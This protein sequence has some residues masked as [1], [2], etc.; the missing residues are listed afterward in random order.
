MK[1]SSSSEDDPPP[2]RYPL[3]KSPF[4]LPTE[5]TLVMSSP[6]LSIVETHIPHLL[7]SVDPSTVL[8]IDVPSNL[9]EIYSRWPSKTSRILVCELLQ[10]QV[11]LPKF[12]ILPS[13]KRFWGG[14]PVHS[15]LGFCLTLLRTLWSRASISGVIIAHLDQIKYASHNLKNLAKSVGLSKMSQILLLPRYHVCFENLTKTQPYNT[16]YNVSKVQKE[17]ESK[18]LNLLILAETIIQE[19]KSKAVGTGLFDPLSNMIEL[20]ENGKNEEQFSGFKYPGILSPTFS[21]RWVNLINRTEESIPPALKEC[22]YWLTDVSKLIAQSYSR[23]VLYGLFMID[24]VNMKSQPWVLTKAGEQVLRDAKC[25]EIKGSKVEWKT[26]K[27][28]LEQIMMEINESRERRREKR[29]RALRKGKPIK[30]LVRGTVDTLIIT[31]KYLKY[32]ALVANGQSERAEYEARKRFLNKKCEPLKNRKLSDLPVEGQAL[33]SEEIRVKNW[34]SDKQ[35]NP[36][37]G[38][39]SNPILCTLYDELPKDLLSYFKRLK[40]ANV[41]LLGDWLEVVRTLEIYSNWVGSEGSKY[42]RVR[43]WSVGGS[44][45]QLAEEESAFERIIEDKKS[46]T[47][48]SSTHQS[49]EMELALHNG[50]VAG[51]YRD[52][53]GNEMPLSMDTRVGR[54]VNSELGRTIIVD[55]RELRNTT[56]SRLHQHGFRLAP[57]QL[58]VGDF[59]LTKNIVV[60]KKTLQDLRNS[61]DNGRLFEQ[62]E[63]MEKHYSQSILLLEFKGDREADPVTICRGFNDIEESSAKSIITKFVLLLGRF[64]K[65]RILWSKSPQHTAELFLAIKSGRDD[66]DV[67]LA[68][69]LGG[70]EQLDKKL[71]GEDANETAVELLLKI[72]GAKDSVTIDGRR[73]T[74]AQ[75]IMEN[76]DNFECLAK[77]SKSDM[78]AWGISTSSVDKIFRY[79]H[80]QVL[81]DDSQQIKKAAKR[82][83]I[84]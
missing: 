47:L 59:V 71:L 48:N 62:C 83:K 6:G 16:E 26:R 55:T 29:L 73:Y 24:F 10:E 14:T 4:E 25:Y 33:L 35:N 37:N 32:T 43:V 49:Q 18:H 40:P 58:Y 38:D 51:S 52:S 20:L 31:E 75:L 54:G 41:V 1:T 50:M 27:T 28:I 74:V 78:K 61:L 67:A 30:D 34:L 60:E 21:Q 12:V 81:V 76:T 13:P 82:R 23:P 65:L 15:I 5:S 2:P 9:K 19:C 3:D 77:A 39:L 79:F 45:E 72:P 69:E 80:K 42:E 84:G 70:N 17:D 11:D 36:S 64:P 68:S 66:P 8:C 56:A 53:S 57:V 46:G 22:I 63:S 7:H 44:G